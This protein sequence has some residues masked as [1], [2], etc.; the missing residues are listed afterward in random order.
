MTGEGGCFRGGAPGEE[1]VLEEGS[2]IM[3]GVGACFRGGVIGYD[4]GGHLF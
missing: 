1:P 3:T 2:L 4:W